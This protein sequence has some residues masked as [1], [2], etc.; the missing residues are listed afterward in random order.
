MFFF[1]FCFC[2]KYVKGSV[3]GSLAFFREYGKEEYRGSRSVLQGV[4]TAWL[5]IRKQHRVEGM[6]LTLES[7]APTTFCHYSREIRCPLMIL[8]AIK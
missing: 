5:S 7:P 8:K 4:F 2:G 6:R 1:C 3:Y